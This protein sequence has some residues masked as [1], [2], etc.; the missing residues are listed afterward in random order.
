[1]VYRYS[2]HHGTHMK[3]AALPSG[4][5]TISLTVH[6]QGIASS[7]EVNW[8]KGCAGRTDTPC[9]VKVNQPA[10]ENDHKIHV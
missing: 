3:N 5:P 10:K 1:M 8:A 6:M 4:L 9:I 2:W 7:P